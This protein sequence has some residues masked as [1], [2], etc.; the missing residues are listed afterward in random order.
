M[1]G[2]REDPEEKKVQWQT[3]IGIWLKERPQGL[4]DTITEAMV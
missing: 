3:Q 1:D 2:N 4:K